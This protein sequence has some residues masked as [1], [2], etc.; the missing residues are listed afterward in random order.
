M[1]PCASLLLA[2]QVVIRLSDLL[3]ALEGSHAA[4][5]GDAPPLDAEICALIA[6]RPESRADPDIVTICQGNDPG[7]ATLATLRLLA[8]LQTRF[9]SER[10]F[11]RLAGWIARGAAPMIDTWRNRDRRI[12]I[13]AALSAVTTEGWLP[14]M[15]ALLDDAPARADD[16]RHAAA[17]EAAIGAI[18]AELARIVAEAAERAMMSRRIGAELASAM[19]ATALAVVFVVAV[20]L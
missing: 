11:P 16:A 1:L 9:A 14:S 10:R 2:G 5:G 12:R 7:A 15:A 13:A 19:G 17:A 6:S 20:L 18:D 8:G 4:E 3:P